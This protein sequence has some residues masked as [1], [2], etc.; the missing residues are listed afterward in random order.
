[1]VAKTEIAHGIF[2]FQLTHPTGALLPE[3]TA[4][5]HL[6]VRVPNGSIRNYSLS[7][8]PQERDRYVIAVK[9]DANGRG[10]S[11]SMVDGVEVGDLLPVTAPQNEF[12]LTEHARQFIFVAGGIGITPILSM[13]RHL[14]ASTDTPFKLYYCTRNPELTAFLNELSGAEFSN[15]VIIHHDFGNPADAYDFWPIFD[16]PSNGTHV[17]CCGPRP[18]M[19]SVLDMTGHWP[20]GTVH[21]EN[22]GVDQSCFTENRPFSVTLKRSGNHLEVPADRSILEVLRDNGIRVSSSCESGTCGSCRTHL[23][24]GDAEHRDRVLRED[25]HHDQIMICVS[26]SRN[27]VLVLDL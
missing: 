10:G 17:Y 26:R 14:K 2:C 4:G 23:I 6:R 9:R 7:N 22:F 8:A 15:T 12:E 25:E 18:L 13:M 5:A 11:L 20:P 21:F 27:A 24:A 1:M 19:D 3:F 16:K